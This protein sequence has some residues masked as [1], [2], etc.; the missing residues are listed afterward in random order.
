MFT[1]TMFIA[2]FITFMTVEKTTVANLINA[3]LSQITT[4]VSLFTIVKLF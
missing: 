3:P 1:F 2:V 4:Q